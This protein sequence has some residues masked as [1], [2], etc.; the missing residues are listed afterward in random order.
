MNHQT[1]P[2]WTGSNAQSS[3]KTRNSALKIYNRMIA[4]TFSK[5]TCKTSPKTRTK[6]NALKQHT[7]HQHSITLG[8]IKRV[9]NEHTLSTINHLHVR[10]ITVIIQNQQNYLPGKAAGPLAL[11]T[12]LRR[13]LPVPKPIK[14]HQPQ[15]STTPPPRIKITKLT[16]LQKQFQKPQDQV[17]LPNMNHLKRNSSQI[18][19][20]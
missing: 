4:S 2:N 16:L 10:Q 3:S 18:K 5:Q 1:K 9:F 17:Y 6:Y 13:P 7:L 19:V 8:Q 14:Q 15:Q 20:K 11:D 12:P